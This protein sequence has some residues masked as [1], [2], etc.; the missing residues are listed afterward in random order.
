MPE[1]EPNFFIVGAARAGT[2]S[3]WHCLRQHPGV[4]MPK[5]KEPH[6]FCD[7]RPPWATDT[8]E[9][10]LRLFAGV[11]AER[12]IG[13]AST[14]YLGDPTTAARIHER[15]PNAKIVI[16]LRH[17]VDRIY[18]LYRLNCSFGAEWIS[19]FERAL[20]VE[21]ERAASQRFRQENP[22]FQAA[23]LYSRSGYVA[24]HVARYQRMFAPEQIHVVV[25]DDLRRNP[26]ATVRGLFDF[27]GVDPDVKLDVPVENR[28]V[29]PASVR[30]QHRLYK[31]WRRRFASG[32]NQPPT[33]GQRAIGI[34][35]YLNLVVGRALGAGRLAPALRERILE[36]YRHDIEQTMTLVGR[37]L[38]TW[39][40]PS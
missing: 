20:D 22:Y 2:T 35:W 24:E 36:R 19:P 18:S 27:L 37:D 17:P 5:E 33:F 9:S 26:Q 3:L 23:Y 16:A 10:Y 15:Y 8:L 40:A 38:R 31:T 28:S 34:A 25:F 32:E 4:F 14:G 1:H 11:G 39:L 30:V 7:N 6:Y 29:L 12:A 21:D 13:E